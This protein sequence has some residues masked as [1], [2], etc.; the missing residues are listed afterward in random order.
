[1][2]AKLYILL[3]FVVSLSISCNDGDYRSKLI[4]RIFENPHK[5]EFYVERHLKYTSPYKE[6]Y[7]SNEEKKNATLEPLRKTIEEYFSS[8]YKKVCEKE[9]LRYT[10]YYGM[11]NNYII[12]YYA[13]SKPDLFIKI[14]WVRNLSNYQLFD[15]EVV[16]QCFCDTL[17]IQ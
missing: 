12:E 16:S 13:G 5:I 11:K 6:R 17:D 15:I 9:V 8:D 3:F 10:N 4:S 1:M 2:L 7:F 14:D